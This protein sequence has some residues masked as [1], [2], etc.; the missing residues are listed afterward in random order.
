MPKNKGIDQSTILA[1]NTG[2]PKA[3]DLHKEALAKAGVS[4]DGGLAIGE[5]QKKRM[6]NKTSGL[7]VHNSNDMYN[8]IL[9]LK[10]SGLLP[11]M[12]R[13]AG[14]KKEHLLENGFGVGGGYSTAGGSPIVPL[15][16]GASKNIKIKNKYAIASKAKELLKK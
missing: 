3:V 2:G 1:L 6:L 14:I 4:I 5:I 9:K 11:E 10:K 7:N 16:G 15:G 12:L 8:T 13:R